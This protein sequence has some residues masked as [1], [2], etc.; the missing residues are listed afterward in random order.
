MSDRLK[1][2]L[3]EE[4]YKQIIDK[5]IKANEIDLLDG[6]IPRQRYN[7][8]NDKLKATNE[9]V[10]A[11]EQQAEE[12]DKLLKESETFKNE[13]E[14]FKTK[15]AD[16]ETKHASELESKNKEVENVLKRSLV[17]EKF[18][19]EGAK[20]HDLLMNNIDWDNVNVKDNALFNFDDT[21]KE[22][23]TK[24]EDLFTTKTNQQTVDSGGQQTQTP[25]QTSEWDFMNNITK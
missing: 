19:T 15:L 2:K 23:K 7:E 14:E 11:L 21:F 6:Y 22:I 25:P 24:Y 18:I 1:E 3:G 10:T 9:K 12:K 16:M 20:H 4:L 17:K 8:I 5:G 13:N